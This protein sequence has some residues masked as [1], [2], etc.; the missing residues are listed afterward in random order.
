MLLE[1]I[2]GVEGFVPKEEVSYGGGTFKKGDRV[3]A[4]VLDFD[5]KRHK[6]VLSIK[7]TLPKPWEEYIKEHPVGS[8]VTGTVEKIEGARAI[9]RLEKGVQGLFTEMTLHG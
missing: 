7:R 1:V 3:S 6:L 2:E 8:R 9:V 4:Y 5:P